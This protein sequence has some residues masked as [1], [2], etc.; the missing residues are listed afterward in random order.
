MQQGLLG[1]ISRSSVLEY[2]AFGIISE[3]RNAR[4]HYMI[5]GVQGKSDYYTAHES[6]VYPPNTTGDFTKR[7]V[8]NPPKT[9]WTR[10]LKFG[11]F[12]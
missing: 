11:T 8:Q 5:C 2:H 9:L 10:E 7:L 3:G 12:S 6:S 1:R 4:C